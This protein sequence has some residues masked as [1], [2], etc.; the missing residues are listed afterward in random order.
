[1]LVE[2]IEYVIS[3]NLMKLS[4]NDLLLQVYYDH[5]IYVE[6]KGFSHDIDVF[7]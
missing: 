3:S 6:M 5:R 1:M 7:S 2:G 4:A